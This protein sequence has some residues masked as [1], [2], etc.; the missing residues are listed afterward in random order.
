MQKHK[1]FWMAMVVGG[2]L[3][4]WGGETNT[5]SLVCE[6]PNYHFGRVYADASVKHQ[7][8]LTNQGSRVV[9]I[10]RVHTSCGCATAGVTTNV[11][12]PGGTSLL[13]VTLDVRK[14]RGHQSKT[15]YCET[16]DPAN[17][18]VRLELNGAVV[19]PIEVQPEGIHFGTVGAAET[20][21]REILLVAAGTNRF[22]VRSVAMSSTQFTATVEPREPGRSYVVKVSS[23]G[24]RS[25]GSVLASLRVETDHP[26]QQTIDIPVVAFVAGDIIPNPSSLLMTPSPTNAPR[27][28]W[29]NLWSPAGKAF[30]VARVDCPS[31]DMAATVTALLP[32]RSRIEVNAWGP[33]TGVDGK[34][35]RVETDLTSKREIL[36]PLRVLSVPDQP[37]TV[38]GT[39]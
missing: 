8:V 26:G 12:P 7:F 36:V 27:T 3:P 23:E 31:P 37:S 38:P 39:P 33:L 14:R 35:L 1:L 32:D 34:V 16:D 21:T 29:L 20:L 17:R 6:A 22:Q 11:V 19:V 9:T 25:P 30:K 15:V 4:L 13:D 24:S 28:Y 2:V 10:R 5:P 18:I